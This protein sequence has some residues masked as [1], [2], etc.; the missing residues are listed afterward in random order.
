MCIWRTYFHKHLCI[1]TIL[2][3][4]PYTYRYGRKKSERPKTYEEWLGKI[5]A[6][7]QVK[8]DKKKYKEAVKKLAEEDK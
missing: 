7:E 6:V 3:F 4:Y 2:I 8:L 1:Y 5:Q